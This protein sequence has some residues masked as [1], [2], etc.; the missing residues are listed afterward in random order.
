[1]NDDGWPRGQDCDDDD[2]DEDT[3][4]IINIKRRVYQALRSI[5]SKGDFAC[6]RGLN[7]ILD[8]KLH[9]NRL[10][11]VV[12]L[13]LSPDDTNAIIDVCHRSPFGKGEET[14]VDTSVRKCWELNT[15]EFDIK[16]PGW[17]NYMKK[18]V[19]DVGKGL[20]VADK[21]SLIRADPYKLLLYEKDA[22]FLSHQDSPKADG[23]F[24][25]LV[26]CLPTEHEG[27]EIVLNHQGKSMQF[28]T[29]TTSIA[30]F[31]YAAW[32]S[33]VFHE[34]KPITRG[35]RLV[36]TYNLI[37]E[38]TD[39]V[40]SA[41]SSESRALRNALKFWEPRAEDEGPYLLLYKLS[42]MYTDSSLS[43]QSMK[44]SDRPRM[45]ALQAACEELGFNL[46]LG[47]VEREVRGSCDDYTNSQGY[48]EIQ[49]TIDDSTIMKQV[50]DSQG[51]LV[52]G[53]VPV[54]NSEYIQ[55]NV[56][57]GVPTDEDYSGY[58]GN[59]GTSVCHFY[60]N[61]AIVIVPK[62][63]DVYFRF[64]GINGSNQE[65][66]ADWLNR[67]LPLIKDSQD[68]ESREEFNHLVE[69]VLEHNEAYEKYHEIAR[70]GWRISDT[71]RYK[72]C[73]TVLSII[74]QGLHT[75]GD[76]ESF[77]KTI[78]LHTAFV[79]PE[80]Y[81]C[82]AESLVSQEYATVKKA[83][84]YIFLKA[85]DYP[86]KQVL[87]A[88]DLVSA[89]IAIPD[90]RRP[91]EWAD[92]LSWREQK[93]AG[94]L[95]RLRNGS[96]DELDSIVRILTLYP[97]IEKLQDT[98][99]LQR[100]VATCGITVACLAKL[101][102]SYIK[103]YLSVEGFRVFYQR[104]FEDLVKDLD[105]DQGL[106]AK[107]VA[108]IGPF[109]TDAQYKS[110]A[111]ESADLISIYE[112]CLDF[113]IPLSV[114][115]AGIIRAIKQS[116]SLKLAFPNI[117]V[118][119]LRGIVSGLPGR[120]S[121]ERRSAESS[122]VLRALL[123]YVL[124]Y[125]QSRSTAVASWSRAPASSCRCKDCTQ[126]NAFLESHTQE[127]LELKISSGR[128]FHIHQAISKDQ[129]ILEETRLSGSPY[130]LVLTK[131]GNPATMWKSRAVDAVKNINSIGSPTA[132]EEF[133]G[134]ASYKSL[135]ALDIVI[136]DRPIDDYFEHSN[137]DVGVRKRSATSELNPEGA[138][139]MAHDTEV[140]DLT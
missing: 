94:L 98:I 8:P 67:L 38:G 35:H 53:Q 119:F 124:R 22:F 21:V 132:L 134:S 30:G 36:L 84:N 62:R 10:D 45:A 6:F 39:N 137:S 63:L 55:M 135:M 113:D 58:T 83:L 23:M 3:P 27:G 125:V 7:G 133:L 97:T 100:Q 138:S 79:S 131:L 25:T 18:I 117:L 20:G 40:P 4:E 140:I 86:T 48:Y 34:I 76:N 15:T 37:L 33:D 43:F 77:E 31:S 57:R 102:T 9:I 130:T 107:P 108:N 139:S 60:R 46:Y 127:V 73:D 17:A 99:T 78:K 51:N 50:I 88:T 32:Y 122:F 116:Q 90:E 101:G 72:F 109:R 56:L 87:V 42:H 114:L 69:L 61:T 65:K 11:R 128:R 111:L 14:L 68:T 118:P 54:R 104:T 82:I 121:D 66:L 19:A 26:V 16:A 95:P 81:P 112:Q 5:D 85:R 71:F 75:I 24:A 120:T 52:C 47:N 44:G 49:D 115:H 103:G 64:R 13:P 126:L 110:S 70:P 93:L 1:M 59:E 89:C 74:A 129:T 80:V 12:K 29:S 2:T 91:S 123:E 136:K 106:E 105:L 96:R 41:P 92:L 28:K